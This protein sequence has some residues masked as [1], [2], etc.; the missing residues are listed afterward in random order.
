MAVKA[1]PPARSRAVMVRNRTGL[2]RVVAAHFKLIAKDAVAQLQLTLSLLGKSDDAKTKAEQAMANIHLKWD[3]LPSE[4]EPYIAAMAV[5]GGELSIKQLGGDNAYEDFGE[6]MRANANVWAKDRAAE[7]VGKKW[8]GG[9]LIDN[10]NAA[11]GI[12]QSTRDSLQAY[13]TAAIEDGDS[14][15]ELADR[16]ENSF[17]FSSERAIMVARTEIAKADSAGAIIGW[18]QTG[19]VKAKSWLS[20]GDDS[21][22]E[23]CTNNEAEGIVPL[24]WDY[25]DGVI[26]PPQHPNCRCTLLPELSDD[27]SEDEG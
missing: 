2:K 20:A 11:W 21:V 5:A 25:G 10:P 14:S 27:D 7:M 16:I 26:A 23:E 6:G 1:Y 22:S 9:E 4:A 24:D 3:D 12:D 19:M 18:Q 17:A 13:V 15:E 8:V